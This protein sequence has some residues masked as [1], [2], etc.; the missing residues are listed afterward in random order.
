MEPEGGVILYSRQSQRWGG[1]RLVIPATY[2]L[3]KTQELLTWVLDD[4][5]TIA[6][7][8]KGRDVPEAFE[9]AFL[10]EGR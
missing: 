5:G 9:D 7:G 3:R 1:Y 10:L 4:L 6:A 2:D 8:G